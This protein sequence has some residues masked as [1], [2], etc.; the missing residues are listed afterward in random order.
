VLRPGG[1]LVLE[2]PNP[3]NLQVGACNFYLDPTHRNPL[4][5]PLS[6]AL[7]ELRGFSQVSVMELHPYPQ[8][9]QITEGGGRVDAI[10][11]QILYGPQDYGVVG[12]KA[13]E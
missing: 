10:L 2:T 9:E 5:S 1:L 8:S 11:N 4:P 13:A 3:A 12:W 7:L 6:A